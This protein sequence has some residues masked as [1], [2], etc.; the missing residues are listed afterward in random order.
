ME[1]SIPIWVLVGEGN[2]LRGGTKTHFKTCVTQ[3]NKDGDRQTEKQKD[4]E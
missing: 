1:I 4:K 2:I 3:S